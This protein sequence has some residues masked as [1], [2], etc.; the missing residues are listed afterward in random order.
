MGSD[1][2]TCLSDLTAPDSE[3][4]SRDGNV[5]IKMNKVNNNKPKVILNNNENLESIDPLQLQK[6]SVNTTMNS[7]YKNTISN[8]QSKQKDLK[9]QRLSNFNSKKNIQIKKDN[10]NNKKEIKNNKINIENNENINN[11]NI[12][13]KKIDFEKILNREEMVSENFNKFFNS[14]K[15]QEMILNMSETNNKICITLHKYLVSLITRRKYKKNKEYF[16]QDKL[17][18][19]NKCLELIYNLN[20]NL[21]KFEKI[22]KKYYTPDGYL[23]YYSDQKIVS[24]MKFDPQKESFNDCIII[25]Y[26]NDDSSSLENILWIYKGQV[27]KQGLPHGFG[28]KFYKSGKKETGY[29]KLGH[30]H[31]WGMSIH[32]GGNIYIGPFFDEKNVTGLGEKFTWKKKALYKGELIDGEKSGKGEE[33]SNEG[34]F[35]GNFYHDKKNGKGKMIY[36]LSGDIYEGDYKNDLFDGKGHYIWKLTGQEYTGDYKNGVMHG[37]GLFEWSNGEFYRGEFVNG[38]KEGEG[39]LHMGNGRIY[40]GPFVNGRP[41][42]IGIYDN[43]VNF[44]GEMEFI[45]GKMNINYLKRKNSNSS[46]STIN[47]NDISNISENKQEGEEKG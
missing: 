39:E 40:I 38:K 34:T 32:Q 14:Q 47:G 13:E 43:G 30:L 10:N 31:G 33:D 24:K 27:N 4:L 42:G 6:D 7:D 16:L 1:F 22:S 19:Y 11:K 3:D 36:K 26:E 28:E 29:Y 25:T 21:K 46:M 37:K 5:N 18:I 17:N 35:I 8:I 41:H 45:D 20:P 12:I 15:G 23:K 9:E 2:C 44:R